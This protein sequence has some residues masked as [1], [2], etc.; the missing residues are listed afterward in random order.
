LF[1]SVIIDHKII[2]REIKQLKYNKLQDL[3]IFTILAVILIT[4][5]NLLEQ[6]DLYFNSISTT[7]DMIPSQI[8]ILFVGTQY[9]NR[10]ILNKL[11]WMVLFYLFLIKYANVFR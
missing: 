7:K 10:A 1:A 11:L 4:D 9:S 3:I 2:H 5:R 8:N 6:V